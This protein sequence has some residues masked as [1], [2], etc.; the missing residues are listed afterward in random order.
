MEVIRGYIGP[1]VESAVRKKGGQN[2]V[3]NRCNDNV[4]IDRSEKRFDKEEKA[5]EGALMSVLEGETLL[6]HLVKQTD[7]ESVIIDETLNILIAGAYS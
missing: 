6:G 3:T 5:E 4:D 7:D 1:I 2:C